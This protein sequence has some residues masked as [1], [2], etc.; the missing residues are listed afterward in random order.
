[1]PCRPRLRSIII[2]PALP[3]VPTPASSPPSAPHFNLSAAGAFT[4]PASPSTRSAGASLLPLLVGSSGSASSLAKSAATESAQIHPGVVSPRPSALGSIDGVIPARP[5]GSCPTPLAA[6]DPLPSATA[7]SAARGPRGHGLLSI[8]V[9]PAPQQ[10]AAPPPLPR[11]P[12]LPPPAPLHPLQPWTAPPDLGRRFAPSSGG[13]RLPFPFGS[14]SRRARSRASM[15]CSSL[16][17]SRPDSTPGHIARYCHTPFSPALSAS[18]PQK[19]RPPP[20]SCFR[21]WPLPSQAPAA[22][23]LVAPPQPRQPPV[24]S[25]SRP[26]PMEYVPGAPSRR[27]DRSSCVIVTTPEM[28][29]DAS[30]LRRTALLATARD[31]RVDINSALVLKAVERDC[32]LPFDVIQ[33]VATFPEDYLIRF[34]E[35]KHRDTALERAFLTVRGVVFDLHPWEP[36][37]DGRTRD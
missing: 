2:A 31:R 29:S 12:L 17:S 20:Q 34:N 14:M 3:L 28:E 24:A 11:S 25:A 21:A 8:I 35:P 1:M 13:G 27:P 26:V 19:L 37:S 18:P 6:A 33:V 30:H 22:R 15:V 5:V 16:W 9:A 7:T 4:P 23:P 32:G 36:L 10:P